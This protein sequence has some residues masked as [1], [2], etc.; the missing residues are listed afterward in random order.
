MPVIA[1]ALGVLG[2][3]PVIL[4]GLG[5]LSPVPAQANALFMAFVIYLAAIL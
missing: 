5:S 2:L 4:C 3:I 1:I